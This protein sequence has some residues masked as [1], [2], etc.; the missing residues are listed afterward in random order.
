MASI[1]YEKLFTD[2]MKLIKDDVLKI[3]CN[4]REK[5][6]NDKFSYQSMMNTI[7][8]KNAIFANCE[9]E[10]FLTPRSFIREWMQGLYKEYG[11]KIYEGVNGTYKHILIEMLKEPVCKD[12]IEYYL[13]RNYY[14]N[15]TARVRYKPADSLKEI[16]FGPNPRFWGLMICPAFRNGKWTN[17]ASEIRRANYEYW[18]I[19]H[20]LST[21]VVAPNNQM[22]IRFDSLDDFIAFYKQEFMQLSKSH[23]EREIMQLYFDYVSSHKNCYEVP[24]LIPE[25]RFNKEE[26]NHKYRLDFTILNV[27]SRKAIGFEISPQSTH[28]YVPDIAK[29]SK[30]Q[31]EVNFEIKENWE[32]ETDKRNDYYS[33]YGISVV[34]FTDKHLKNIKMCFEK[35]KDYLEERGTTQANDGIIGEHLDKILLEHGL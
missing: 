12:F 24:L 17:D 20:V 2:K 32:K 34:T 33:Q 18:T 25:L 26:K 8:S 23:Y 15:Y 31:T 11:E 16:W 19:G 14:R 3:Y 27:Y 6:G 13:V 7:G 5:E 35:I 30:T 9:R 21:G 28:M 4:L 1:D 22:P 29:Y 10:E